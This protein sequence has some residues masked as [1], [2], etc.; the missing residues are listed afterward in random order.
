MPGGELELFVQSQAGSAN[1]L[2][3]LRITGAPKSIGRSPACHLQLDDP[4]RL[5]SRSHLSV[6]SDAGGRVQLKNISSSSPAFIDGAELAPGAQCEVRAGQSIVLGRFLLGLRAASVAPA[7][8]GDAISMPPIPAEFDVFAAP[9]GSNSASGGTLADCSLDEFAPEREVREELF[10]GLPEFDARGPAAIPGEDLPG[11]CSPSATAIDPLAGL[12]G[13][14]E[15]AVRASA[16]EGALGGEIDALFALPASAHGSAPQPAVPENT[17]G[18]HGESCD[19]LDSILATAEP[20][21]GMPAA[22]PPVASANVTSSVTP[23][24]ATAVAAAPARSSPPA[25]RST[26]SPPAIADAARHSRATDRIRQAQAQPGQS[27]DMGADAAALRHAFARGCGVP[28]ERMGD[29]DEASLES[30]GRLMAA[31]VGGTLQLVHARSSTKHE[32]RANVTIIASSGNN[33]LKF[34]PD[35]YAALVQLL[36]RGLPGFMAPEEAIADAFE[37]LCAHQVGLL[38]ASRSAMYALAGRLS[39]ERVQE[40]AG[41]PR[42]FSGLLPSA[43]KARLWDR[44]VEAHAALLGEAREEFDAVFQRAFVSAYEGEVQRLQASSG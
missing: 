30:L 21:V 18:E 6:S 44:Y 32:M 7:R 23:S 1:S 3:P 19:L 22:A 4:E 33:P 16:G 29:F 15:S 34:A 25:H 35:T 43:H 31:L 26:T 37:D 38:S 27:A 13:T 11:L 24:A 17:Q 14:A 12:L 2:P 9:V 5:V 42:G 8:P 10:Q 36:G 20:V 41:G 40:L 39:P 28:V